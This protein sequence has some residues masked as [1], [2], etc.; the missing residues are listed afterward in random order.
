MASSMANTLFSGFSERRL[1]ASSAFISPLLQAIIFFQIVFKIVKAV[2]HAFVSVSAFRH[3]NLC[4]RRPVF[5]SRSLQPFFYKASQM[6][7][8]QLGKIIYSSYFSTAAFIVFF[9]FL[10]SSSSPAVIIRRL[11]SGLRK[12]LRQLPGVSFGKAL[13]TFSLSRRKNPAEAP[14]SAQI[15]Y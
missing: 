7:L 6:S 1:L 12:K 13:K 10:P 3:Y 8:L 5:Q 14:P 2:S 15:K 11:S 4:Y 9:F